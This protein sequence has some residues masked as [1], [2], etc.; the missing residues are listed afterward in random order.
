MHQCGFRQLFRRQLLAIHTRYALLCFV[1]ITIFI[2]LYPN[3]APN[4]YVPAEC[5]AVAQQRGEQ[6]GL[7]F[8][9]IMESPINV[10]SVMIVCV[11]LSCSLLCCVHRVLC[12]VIGMVPSLDDVSTLYSLI[13]SNGLTPIISCMTHHNTN[14]VRT[15]TPHRCWKT[16]LCL[17]TTSRPPRPSFRSSGAWGCR[18]ACAVLE[19]DFALLFAGTVCVVLCYV[20][21][22]AYCVFG[23]YGIMHKFL[24]IMHQMCSLTDAVTYLHI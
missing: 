18:A 19:E 11:L 6:W 10:L 9:C 3:I 12:C 4:R 7:R 8:P 16:P 23:L 17:C 13:Y 14:I 20:L 5:H 24:F 21:R 2:Y 1:S 15:N 22:I